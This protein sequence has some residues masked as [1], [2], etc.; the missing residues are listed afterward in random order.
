[1]YRELIKSNQSMVVYLE[2]QKGFQ[3]F[4][5]YCWS[6]D[7]AS[8]RDIVTSSVVQ[9]NNDKCHEKMEVDHYYYYF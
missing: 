2:T 5:F 7:S 3:G 8:E 4:I 9:Y 1:M 6:L